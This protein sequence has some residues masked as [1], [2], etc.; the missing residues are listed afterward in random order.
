M[1][2][3]WRLVVKLLWTAGLVGTLVLLQQVR[4]DFVYQAF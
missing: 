1:T 4:Y 3:R 2:A